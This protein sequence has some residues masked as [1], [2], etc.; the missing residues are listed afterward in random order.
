MKR[1]AGPEVERLIQ[2]LGKLPGLGPRSAR[3]AVL[4]L[5]KNRDKLMAPLTSALA[6]A[7]DKVVE[8]HICGNVD[9]RSPCGIC[10][11][12]RRNSGILIVVVTIDRIQRGGLSSVRLR[13]PIARTRCS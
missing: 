10:S 11:D 6:D 2:L 7:H 9:T 13:A 4:H 8:C 3:R 12:P 5:V 1:Q